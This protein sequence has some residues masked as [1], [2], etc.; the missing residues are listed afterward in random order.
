MTEA[1]PGLYLDEAVVGYDAYSLWHTGRD[2]HGQFLPIVLR[3]FNDYRG[4]LFSYLLA[5][6]VGLAGLSVFTV[7][8]TSSYLG[9]LVVAAAYR[10]TYELYRGSTSDR[11]M[12]TAA[13]ASAA[14]LA[15]APWHVHFSRMAIETNTAALSATL[16]VLAFT[17]WRR[18]AQGHLL[19]VS[20]I[21]AGLG[22]YGYAVMKLVLP[23]LVGCLVVT[24]AR[25][26]WAHRRW[27]AT[28]AIV[29]TCIAMPM[30]MQTVLRP[31]EMQDHFRQIT[32][33]QPGRPIVEIALEAFRNLLANV[34]HRYL[35]LS[36]SPD[37]VLHPQSGGQLP[38]SFAPL[39]LLGVA[40]AVRA[41]VKPHQAG[42]AVAA[43]WLLVSLVPAMLTTHPSGVGNPQRTLPAVVPWCILAGMGY[44]RVD[45]WRATVPRRMVIGA[46]VL[47]LGFEIGSF[48]QYY[49]REYPRHAAAAFHAGMA[50][51]TAQIEAVQRNYEVVFF[52]PYTNDL[53]YVH[54]LFYSRYDPVAL[55][56]DLPEIHP[57]MPDRVVRLGKYNFLDESTDLWSNGLPGLF[58][59]PSGAVDTAGA[60]FSETAIAPYGLPSFEIL[61]REALPIAQWRWIAQCEDPVVPLTGHILEQV[62]RANDA[63]R[64]VFD[65][66]HGWIYPAGAGRGIYVLQANTSDRAG[67]DAAW[68]GSFIELSDPIWRM[69]AH[70][71]QIQP[72]S[73][74]GSSAELSGAVHSGRI[75]APA[76]SSPELL[77]DLGTSNVHLDGGLEFVDAALRRPSEA[78][79]EIE[80]TTVWQVTT[81]ITRALSL[82]AHIIAPDGNTLGAADALAI[83]PLELRPGDIFVQRHMLIADSGPQPAELWL[84]TGAY[85]LDTSE[86]WEVDGGPRVMLPSDAI[87]V[88]LES[89]R[90]ER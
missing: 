79:T 60:D 41:G 46:I 59:L 51:L 73:V 72:F 55:Q 54:I 83:S 9:I 36:G 78:D 13:V 49:F 57:A 61:G 67:P 44:A 27:A 6:V 48:Y 74:Y 24:N 81:P 11:P 82:M 15:I 32:I 43:G 16:V 12:T 29:G 69:N 19:I 47:I 39:I 50:G 8:L 17:R 63:R 4:A 28:A 62:V 52:T 89:V 56:N 33:L 30:V 37:Q 80:F 45:A 65:C 35:F 40:G 26:L 68:L 22:L 58:I 88:R 70:S 53:P 21:C 84:R 14:L 3:A 77:S 31:D 75:G 23:L 18:T 1:P 25:V 71:W 85:W 86:R 7:R 20:S 87:F 5:P 76:D 64:I 90:Q 2:H 42:G 34:N 10:S 66:T 38:M